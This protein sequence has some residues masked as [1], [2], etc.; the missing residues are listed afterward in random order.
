MR[1]QE[2]ALMRENEEAER[3][4][5]QEDAQMRQQRDEANIANR[6]GSQS[7]SMLANGLPNPPG[8]ELA[9]DSDMNPPADPRKHEVMSH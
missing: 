9:L 6:N 4:A 3:M 8:D 7:Q 5:E 2:E 1:E